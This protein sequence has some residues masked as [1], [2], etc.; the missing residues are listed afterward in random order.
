MRLAEGMPL[1]DSIAAWEALGESAALPVPAPQLIPS[2]SPFPRRLSGFAAAAVLL[3]AVGLVAWLA[4]WGSRPGVELTDGGKRIQLT[5]RG[6]LAGLD[7]LPAAQRQEVAAALRVGHLDKPPEI[8]GLAGER[9]ALR[10]GGE[11]P[12][13][14]VVLA[15]LGTAVL[16]GRPTFRWRPFSG[17]ESYQVKI[18]DASLNPA[19][20]SSPIS[21]TDWRPSQPLPAGVFNWQVVAHSTGTDRT[22]PDPG[23]PP[24]RFR[25]LEVAQAEALRHAVQEAGGSHLAL[26]I[27][28]AHH[29]L[30]D[31]AERELDQVVA[32]NPRSAI[33]R[34]LLASVR[35]WRPAA[36]QVPSPTSTK[37][38]Q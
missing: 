31:D 33:A 23:S 11:A 13:G 24:A 30:V 8:A 7:S 2:P 16:D 17:G 29:G 20:D 22:A 4:G 14:F 25:V 3:A 15:P 32:A 35:S 38:A 5:S 1:S 10:G 34:G 18:F 37:A 21:G 6:E 12:S 26:G 28:Y 9:S 27:L 19:T 36:S